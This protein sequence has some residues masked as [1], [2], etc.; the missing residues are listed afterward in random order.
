MH[1]NIKNKHIYG[2]LVIVLIILISRNNRYLSKECE[3]CIN[4]NEPEKIVELNID[5]SLGKNLPKLEPKRSENFLKE[6]KSE[7]DCRKEVIRLVKTDTYT[8]YKIQNNVETVLYTVPVE[9]FEKST[10]TCSMFNQLRR[11]RNLKVHSYALFGPRNDFYYGKMV[12]N[13][14]NL[15]KLYPGW[16]I[17]VSHDNSI[18]RSIICE[19]ECAR[20]SGGK[21]LDNIDFCDVTKMP[22]NGLNESGVWSAFY[23]HPMKY[24]WLAAGD[25][26]VDVFTSRDLDGFLIEREVHAVEEWLKSNKFGHAMRGLLL[27]LLLLLLLIFIIIIIIT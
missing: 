13:S 22:E 27:L 16:I 24:R 12:N 21:Y 10:F 19:A 18:D 20:D 14:A 26:F 9:D 3:K 4:P 1:L 23:M 7:C 25:S 2:I 15:N 6:F 17:R 11:G 5:L 8:I